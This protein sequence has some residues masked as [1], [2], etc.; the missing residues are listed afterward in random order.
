MAASLSAGA[1]DDDDDGAGVASALVDGNAFGSAIT[2]VDVDDIGSGVPWAGFCVAAAASLA[3]GTLA[4]GGCGEEATSSGT[5][6]DIAHAT[7]ALIK[8]I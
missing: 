5:G 1:A 7:K 8:T 4:F 3:G 2:S 6:N